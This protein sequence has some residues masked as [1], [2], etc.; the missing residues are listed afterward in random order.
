MALRALNQFTAGELSPLLDARVDLDK[1][2]AGCQFLENFRVMPWGGV[3]YRS[4]TLFIAATKYPDQPSRLIPFNFST[5]L[6]YVLEL[7]GGYIRFYRDGAQ[8]QT[9]PGV[10]YEIINDFDVTELQEVQYRQIND[11][12][13]MVHMNHPVRKITRVTETNWTTENV[14][15]TYPAL[16]DENTSSTTLA[17]AAVTGAG[18][19]LVASADT[20][21]AASV[22]GYYEIRHRRPSTK[23]EQDISGATATSAAIAVQGGWTFVTTERWYGRIDIERSADGVTGWEKIRTYTGASDFNANG[24]GLE[25][26]SVFL[27]IVWTSSGDPYGTPPWV[28]TPPTDYVKAR[29]TIYTQDTIVAG[30]VIISGFT[31][32]QN[33]TC[34]I[35]NTLESTAATDI[36]SEGAWS[37]RRG[38]PRTLGLFEQRMF[39]AGTNYRPNTAW[40]SVVADFENFQYSDF[41]D[42]AVAYQFASAQQNPIQWLVSLLRLHAGTSGG[43]HIIAS[44][45]LDE[46]LTPSNVTVR[47]PTAYGSEYMQAVKV[48]SAIIFLQRQGR[49]I[50]EL[51]ELSV[52]ANPSDYAAA[53]LTLLAEHITSAGIAQ[54]DYARI[55]DPTLYAVMGNGAMAVMAYNKEQNINAWSRYTTKGNFESVAVVYGSPADV[56]YVIVNRTIGGVTARYVEVFTAEIPEL[57]SDFVY[58]DAAVVNVPGGTVITGLSHLNGE[59]V[60][61][62]AGP[63]G[64]FVSDSL[65]VSS[66]SVRLPQ[67]ETFV[68]VG[69]P[70]RGTV[71]PMKIDLQLGD[72]SSQGRMKRISKMCFR[73]K[74]TRGGSW[75]NAA[76]SLSALGRWNVEIPFRDTQDVMDQ[77]P[78]LF[79]GDKILPSESTNGTVTDI[80]VYQ[81]QPL[82]MTILGLFATIDFVGG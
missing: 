37:T 64:H 42:G 3:T 81:E 72:G 8:V 20:F 18:V 55:P 75:G 23:L 10:A 2:A 12:I 47:D 67:A 25:A 33:A 22:G 66:G 57:T 31:D 70:Y 45:N 74:T 80:S 63:D 35:V 28:G 73:F 39:F 48:D 16:L 56:A 46:P 30:L 38:Y 68:R 62:V 19:A 11:V 50:R 61:V 7:G 29:A 40:G 43:E 49:R 9:S 76:T 59:T 82:P 14:I 4:G 78:P 79:T 1:Y 51:R 34:V 36:W 17:A 65:I 15:W 53:D 60:S 41:D 52:Y 32:A 26:T 58:L 77:A 44:G 6:S 71:T 54:I 13:Y 21:T 27:R 24:S 5:S 69:L